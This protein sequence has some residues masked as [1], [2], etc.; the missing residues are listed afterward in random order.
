[1]TGL[2]VFFSYGVSL[3]TWETHGML[4]REVELYKRLLP[5][6]G[7][8]T[9]VTYGDSRELEYAELLGDIQLLYNRWGLPPHWY[10]RLA[11]ILHFG[12]FLGSKLLKTNQTSGAMAAIPVQ[13]WFR[14]KLIVRCGFMWSDHAAKMYGEGTERA[15]DIFRQEH[16]AFRNADKIVVTTPEMKAYAVEQHNIESEKISVIPNFVDVEAFSHGTSPPRDNRTVCY[17]GRLAREQ[18]NVGVL[19][20]AMIGIDAK[21]LIIG[22]GPERKDLETKA[23]KNGVDAQFK[24]VIP[25][26]KVA[27]YLRSST[28]FVLP[29]LFEG[30]P[31]ALMEAMASGTPVIGANSP[32]IREFLTHNQNGLICE[33]SAGSIR[34]S[35][36]TLLANNDLRNRLGA[37]GREYINSNFSLDHVADLETELYDALQLKT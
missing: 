36:G 35:I 24:G 30:Q 31:K 8:I 23:K 25:F 5:R 1:M 19:L 28:M 10:A 12:S 18:K 34:N 32:G 29:S 14:K 20:D 17:V 2:T 33:P 7:D 26:P 9:F 37:S 11:P 16:R 27:N 6:V 4:L 13:R 21:L 22:D 15:M 3:Q